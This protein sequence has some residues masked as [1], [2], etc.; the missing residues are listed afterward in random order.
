MCT[1]CRLYYVFPKCITNG[2]SAHVAALATLEK[3]LHPVEAH[4]N[5]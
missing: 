5:L 3:K 2:S 4:A 1:E